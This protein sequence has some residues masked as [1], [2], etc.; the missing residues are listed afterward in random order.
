M[1]RRFRQTCVNTEQ[2]QANAD[3]T[4]LDIQLDAGLGGIKCRMRQNQVKSDKCRTIHNQNHVELDRCKTR[5]N[6]ESEPIQVID[7]EMLHITT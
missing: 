5:H 6:A 4:I 7:V 3:I 1:K 2:I